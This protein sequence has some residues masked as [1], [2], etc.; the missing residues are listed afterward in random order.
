MTCNCSA[1]TG[2][3]ERPSRIYS[4]GYEAYIENESLHSCPYDDFLCKQEWDRGWR[5]SKSDSAIGADDWES[6]PLEE[7]RQNEEA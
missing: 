4:E 5:D 3:W 2:E 7:L 1:C 6:F